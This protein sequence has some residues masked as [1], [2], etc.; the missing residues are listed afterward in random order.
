MLQATDILTRARY[1]LLD[2]N[3]Q[4]WSDDELLSYLNGGMTQVVSLKPDALPI[5]DLVALDPGVMQELPANGV[6]LLDAVMNGQGS[7]VTLQSLH[8]FSR[9]H[10]DWAKDAE[11]PTRYVLFDPRLPRH[12]HVYPQASSGRNVWLKYGIMPDRLDGPN[13]FIDFADW[14][15]T[16]LWAFVVASAY[17]KNAQRQNLAK[18]AQFMAM[19]TQFVAGN[20]QAERFTASHAEGPQP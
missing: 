18:S 1:T 11:G 10:P 3:K 4:G 19:F 14:Y 13:K 16:P 7:T 17:A 5:V 6:L 9:V 15:E 12:Y 8:E 20:T 2:A